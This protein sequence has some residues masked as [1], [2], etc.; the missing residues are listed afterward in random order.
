MNSSQNATTNAINNV[1]NEANRKAIEESKRLKELQTKKDALK[2]MNPVQ[3]KQFFSKFVRECN[4]A[5]ETQIEL[6]KKLALNG[7]ELKP[8]SVKQKI[9]E[10]RSDLKK[11][12]ENAAKQGKTVTVDIDGVCPNLSTGVSSTRTV[13]TVDTLIDAWGLVSVEQNTA[14]IG[15]TLSEVESGV[16]ESLIAKDDFNSDESGESENNE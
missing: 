11:L 8:S 15:E 5:G 10:I 13:Q 4:E 1:S 3:K 12:V 14:T 6:Q 16:D 7:W 9:A 2:K